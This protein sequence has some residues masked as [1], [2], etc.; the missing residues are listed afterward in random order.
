MKTSKTPNPER[1]NLIRFLRKQNKNNKIK[2][3]RDLSKRLISPRRRN[4]TVNVSRLNRYTVANDLAVVP[5]KVLGTGQI[6]HPLTVAAFSFSET[7]KEKIVS[8]KGLCLSFY[9]I[10][11][12]HP[13]GSNI[14]VI[15]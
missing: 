2:I 15:G 12:Q 3:W 5:G 4:I 6:T 9:E 10:V 11:E 1:I 14:K 7:A 13:N 8:A